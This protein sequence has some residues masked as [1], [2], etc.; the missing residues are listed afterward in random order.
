[1]GIYMEEGGNWD[2]SA[3]N[4][5]F[6]DFLSRKINKSYKRANRLYVFDVLSMSYNKND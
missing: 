2:L 4:E 5:Y 3:L 6:S 1:M